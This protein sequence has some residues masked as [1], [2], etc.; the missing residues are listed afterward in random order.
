MSDLD[1]VG[2]TYPFLGQ[3][4]T[5]YV[6]SDHASDKKNVTDIGTIATWVHE[7][8]NSIA[9]ITNTSATPEHPENFFKDED[10]GA[11]LEE[12]VF[13]SYVL[14]NGTLYNK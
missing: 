1:G 4:Y 10:S 3:A 13:G 11:A 2:A 5:N 7:L 6:A 8:G 14:P 12:C 9:A